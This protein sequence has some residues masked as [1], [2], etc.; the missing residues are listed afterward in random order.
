M[1][2]KLTCYPDLLAV[3]FNCAALKIEHGE[4]NQV[5]AGLGKPYVMG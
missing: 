1:L 3:N 5:P 2:Q 4:K